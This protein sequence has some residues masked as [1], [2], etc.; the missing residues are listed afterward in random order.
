MDVLARIDRWG[1]EAPDRL[2]FDGSGRLTYGELRD[3]AW[4]LAARL[5]THADDD[6]T[7][8]VVPGHKEPELIVAFVAAALAGRPYVPIDSNLPTARAERIA[9]LAGSTLT[10]TPSSIRALLQQPGPSTPLAPWP[11]PVQRSAVAA[12]PFYV[13]FT[14][15]STGEPKG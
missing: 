4:R 13:L 11:D 9:A 8:I 3:A 7:P 2:A 14:S 10:L 6:A 12:R 1:R 15:G 5:R